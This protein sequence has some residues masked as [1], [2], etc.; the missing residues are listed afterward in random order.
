MNKRFDET[1]PASLLQKWYHDL[2]E[3]CAVLATRI[4]V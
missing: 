3:R 4:N 2:E 1:Q